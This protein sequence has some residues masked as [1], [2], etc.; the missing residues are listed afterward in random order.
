MKLTK[1]QRPETIGG[2]AIEIPISIPAPKGEILTGMEYAM[3]Q[4]SVYSMYV[5]AYNHAIA[6][7]NDNTGKI[8]GKIDLSKIRKG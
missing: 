3:Y 6:K 7:M 1:M 5:R 8:L 4:E 2:N